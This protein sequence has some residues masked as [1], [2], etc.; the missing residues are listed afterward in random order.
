MILRRTIGWT[1]V[2]GLWLLDFLILKM[3]ITVPGY[4]QCLLIM[5]FA[6]QV[7]RTYIKHAR[8]HEKLGKR[9]IRFVKF[10][11]LSV[12]LLFLIAMIPY[13]FFIKLP[14]FVIWLIICLFVV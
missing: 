8:K 9:G 11:F 10:L 6:Y 13:D 14:V 3:G 2:I 1:M 12:F 7:C 4:L 5:A